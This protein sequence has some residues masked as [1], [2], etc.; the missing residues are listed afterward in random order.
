MADE[1]PTILRALAVL[2]TTFYL[3]RRHKPAMARTQPSGRY[4]GK[5]GAARRCGRTIY[6]RCGTAFDKSIRTRLAKV[7]PPRRVVAPLERSDGQAQIRHQLARICEAGEFADFS[8]DRNCKHECNA[9]PRQPASSANSASALSSVSSND[10]PN[11]MAIILESN[12]VPCGRSC[13]VS[14]RR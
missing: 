4:R 12:A 14:H 2:A 13:G 3:P 11:G 7:I 1:N 6:G 8:D 10:R 9:A 5:L